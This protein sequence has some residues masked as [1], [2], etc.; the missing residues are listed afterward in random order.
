M[1]LNRVV[2]AGNLTRDPQVRAVGND[3]LV[4]GF[5]IAINR[6]YKTSGGELKEEATFIEVECW[7]H[8]AKFV[9]EFLK[10]G[11]NVFLEG[12]LKLDTWEDKEGKKQS[13]LK[14][15]ADNVQ[16]LERRERSE[17]STARNGADAAPAATA[18]LD[19]EPPF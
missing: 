3:K 14:V 9:G 17:A 18:S 12:A 6:K 11:A 15:V 7:G 2:L 13:R 19:S 8:S 16:S 1:F 5:A 10:K 4:A